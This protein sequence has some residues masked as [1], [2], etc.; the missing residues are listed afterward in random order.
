MYG[1]TTILVDSGP[2]LFHFWEGCC[3]AWLTWSIIISSQK[4][5]Q[6]WKVQTTQK[7]SYDS[8]MNHQKPVSTFQKFHFSFYPISHRT[9]CTTFVHQLSPY[10]RYQKITDGWCNTQRH[11][12][13]SNASTSNHATGTLIHKTPPQHTLAGNSWTTSDLLLWALSWD[14]WIHLRINQCALWI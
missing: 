13:Q 10:R 4:F 3:H 8:C 2:Y 11:V 7:F 5:C 9:W 14:F 6:S 1:T 12:Q